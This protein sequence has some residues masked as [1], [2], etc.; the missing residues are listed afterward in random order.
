MSDDLK[1]LSIDQKMEHFGTVLE[2]LLKAVGFEGA[3]MVLRAGDETFIAARFPAC[4]DECPHPERCTVKVFEEAA[5]DLQGQ[6]AV[7]RKREGTMTKVKGGFI[8]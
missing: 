5:L 2:N 1:D 4:T 7:I 3:V 8:Q 6:A